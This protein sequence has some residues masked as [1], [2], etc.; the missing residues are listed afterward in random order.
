MA[1][2]CGGKLRLSR[3]T[4]VIAAQPPMQQQQMQQ[5]WCERTRHRLSL[6]QCRQ[7]SVQQ[8][9]RV[10]RQMKQQQPHRRASRLLKLSNLRQLSAGVS[11]MRRGALANDRH[12]RSTLL[13]LT[14]STSTLRG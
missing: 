1:I 9:R 4:L 10:R 2:C 11:K 14:R 3:W 12:Q 5:L 6:Q 7:H 13:M 8:W